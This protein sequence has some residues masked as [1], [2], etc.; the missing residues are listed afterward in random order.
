[1]PPSRLTPTLF[2]KLVADLDIDG[3]REEDGLSERAVREMNRSTLRFYTVPRLERFN[4]V[5]MRNTVKRELN[6][7]LNTTRLSSVEDLEPYPEV[8]T[9]VLNYGVPD[10]TGKAGQG[11][12]MQMRARDIREAIRAFEPRIDPQTLEVEVSTEGDRDNAVTY[13]VRG[14]IVSAV[15][16]MTVVYKTD[17]EVDTGA[18]SVRD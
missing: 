16:A 4:E 9:S 15:K 18:A 1:M 3:L 17:V 11:R 8:Q 12:V 2:D 10:L 6:W 13:V 5:A 7:L 14:D